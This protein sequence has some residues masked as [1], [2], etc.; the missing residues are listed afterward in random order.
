ML[1]DN[2]ELIKA[3]I[4]LVREFHNRD[5]SVEISDLGF[6]TRPDRVELHV[7]RRGKKPIIE[8]NLKHHSKSDYKD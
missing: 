8:V 3:L 1:H 6:S 2:E 4:Q 7:D 5:C